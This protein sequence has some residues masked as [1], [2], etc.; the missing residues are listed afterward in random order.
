MTKREQPRRDLAHLRMEY[1]REALS[2]A[3]VERD[4]IR[5]FIRWLD[6]AVA[7]ETHEPNAMTLATSDGVRPS[8]R[9]V[10]MKHVDGEGLVFFT[11][12]ESRKA[13][14]LDSNPHAAAVFWWPELERQVRVEGTVTR[15]SAAESAEYFGRRPPMSRLA[16]AASPQSRVVASREELERLLA[17][18]AA[19][20]SPENV[21]CPSH[22]GGYRL[23][24]HTMEFWQGRPGRLH[25][26]IEYGLNEGGAWVIRRLAP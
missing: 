17:E 1:A 9:V 25:D 26:R 7:A 16:A 8:A 23:R 6:E 12:Y 24:P 19:K 18:V 11:N 13:N 3:E 5:Q 4:P 15:T 21:P 10:L 22:W 2:E 20:Y 14:Q